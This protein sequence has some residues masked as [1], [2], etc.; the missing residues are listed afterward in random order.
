MSKKGK[1]QSAPAQVEDV[2]YV[3][4]WNDPEFR[5]NRMEDQ[6]RRALANKHH[7]AVIAVDQAPAPFTLDV[8]SLIEIVHARDLL[9]G[10]D[11]KP[12]VS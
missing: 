5:L 12:L 9:V 7:L 11:G 2:T 8:G 3:W 10:V 6:A 4:E 1:R